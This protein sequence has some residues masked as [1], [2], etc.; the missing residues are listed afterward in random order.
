VMMIMTTR[1]PLSTGTRTAFLTPGPGLGVRISSCKIEG[2][3]NT[4]M[5]LH[6]C[7]VRGL[8]HLNRSC[9]PDGGQTDTHTDTHTHRQPL[10][11]PGK[12]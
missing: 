7:L 1:R 11:G 3:V 12:N 10:C 8:L 5:S 2:M 4:E 6:C 9:V